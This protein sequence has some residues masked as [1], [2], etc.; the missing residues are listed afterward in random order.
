MDFDSDGSSEASGYDTSEF[1][2]YAEV[3]ATNPHFFGGHFDYRPPP[4]VD[5]RLQK[6]LRHD[7]WRRA[8][9]QT[10]MGSDGQAASTRNVC[11]LWRFGGHGQLFDYDRVYEMPGQTCISRLF[12]RWKAVGNGIYEYKCEL[13]EQNY[14]QQ[15]QWWMKLHQEAPA[16]VRHARQPRSNH[17]RIIAPPI[18]IGSLSSLA[19]A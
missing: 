2:W 13:G 1:S 16:P 7:E 4:G 10:A 14:T 15:M 12:P 9:E 11:L 18:R 17:R 8:D 19:F 5:R 3:S 6:A